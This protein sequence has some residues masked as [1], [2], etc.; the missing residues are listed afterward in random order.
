MTKKLKMDGFTA[1]VPH[2]TNSWIVPIE[3]AQRSFFLYRD[4]YVYTDTA[5]GEL[6][7]EHLPNTIDLINASHLIT[8]GG[9]VDNR[10]WLDVLILDTPNGKFIQ[11]QM[12]AGVKYSPVYRAIGLVGDDRVV[13]EFKILTFDLKA[14]AE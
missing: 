7:D 3:L 5:F 13:T 8:N 6:Y 10:L 11:K 1:G 12:D 4:R 2:A 14:E 9:F